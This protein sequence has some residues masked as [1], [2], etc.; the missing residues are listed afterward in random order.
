MSKEEGYGFQPGKYLDGAARCVDTAAM[1]A[2]RQEV[3]QAGGLTDELREKAGK[4]GI[5][6]SRYCGAANSSLAGEIR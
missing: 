4:L 1:E 2:L 3:M 6:P 5:H